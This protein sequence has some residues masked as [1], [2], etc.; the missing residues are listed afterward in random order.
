MIRFLLPA[1]AT[2]QLKT[3]TEQLLACAPVRPFAALSSAKR[4]TL[5]RRR[6]RWVIKIERGSKD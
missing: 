5:R 4:T 1:I 3:K 6:N 2:L